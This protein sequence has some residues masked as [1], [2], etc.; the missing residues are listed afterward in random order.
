MKRGYTLIEVLVTIAIVALLTIL[1]IPDIS[2]SLK[3]NNLA[4][5][6]ELV[7]SSVQSARLLS[8][9]TQQVDAGS[10]NS[11]TGYYGVY[12]TTNQSKIYIERISD[13]A[14]CPLNSNNNNCT[15][16]EIDLSSGTTISSVVY[17]TSDISKLLIYF[18]APTQQLLFAYGSASLSP[19]SAV[20]GSDMI[21]IKLL[22]NGKTA[23]LSI[24]PI[25]GEVTSTSYQQ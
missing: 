15:V 24:S 14:D 20:S 2:R 3:N 7:S 8:G 13:G 1:F 12:F 6:V 21:R 5:D 23:I 11:S 22:N 19:V 17:N 25:T 18:Q 4:G 9:S 10:N 16:Q